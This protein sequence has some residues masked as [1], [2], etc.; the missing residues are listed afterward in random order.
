MRVSVIPEEILWE[1]ISNCLTGRMERPLP[2][3][4]HFRKLP[5]GID[6][7]DEFLKLW[8][9]TVAAAVG[10]EVANTIAFRPI[11]FLENDQVV[12]FCTLDEGFWRQARMEFSDQAV[13]RLWEDLVGRQ[14]GKPPVWQKVTP[15]DALFL[16]IVD[17]RLT[18]RFDFPWLH[19][20][21][22]SWLVVTMFL[23]RWTFYNPAELPWKIY[24]ERPEKVPLPLRE[25]LIE[26]TSAFFEALA[27]A[28]HRYSQAEA[29]QE[30]ALV[31]PEQRRVRF[32]FEHAADIL[33]LS[34]P[35]AFSIDL[36]RKA[37]ACWTGDGTLG[38]DDGRF[39]EGSFE[40][41]GLFRHIEAFQREARAVAAVCQA[42]G[43]NHKRDHEITILEDRFQ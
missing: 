30:L 22:A 27:F 14:Q 6:L 42:G 39:L 18:E 10:R 8:Q 23:N 25:V 38:L 20:A 28:I 15:A 16:S 3:R 40:E 11:L 17:Q 5:I 29:N 31:K 2:Y 34:G 4:E 35:N 33:R 1:Y 9:K 21:D 19:G 36:V 13:F 26:H 7:S 41:F 12:R 37:T 24:L 32:F 43:V